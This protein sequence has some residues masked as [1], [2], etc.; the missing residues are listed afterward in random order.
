[1]TAYQPRFVGNILTQVLGFGS[2]R[3]NARYFLDIAG[4][5]ETLEGPRVRYVGKQE[6]L[7]AFAEDE[8]EGE[9][10]HQEPEATV[11]GAGGAGEEKEEV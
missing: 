10:E 8:P 4:F 1:M 6:T 5:E 7:S 11:G 9:S 2:H 3:G